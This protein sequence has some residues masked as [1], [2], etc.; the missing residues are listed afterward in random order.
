MSLN[1]VGMT[2]MDNRYR[3]WW[4]L[5]LVFVLGLELASGFY[6]VPNWAWAVAFAMFGLGE[7]R[8]VYRRA[9][10][11]DTLSEFLWAFRAGGWSRAFLVGGVGLYLATRF[12]MIGDVGL[13]IPAWVP[14]AELASGLAGWL[15]VHLVNMGRN[16]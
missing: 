1:E 8:G 10:G 12:Y 7:A 11:G 16:G 4:G 5:F 15:V 6:A 9:R 14:R 2:T 3:I 13:T